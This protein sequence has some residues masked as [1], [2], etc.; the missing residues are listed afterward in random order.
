M[1]TAIDETASDHS[2]PFVRNNWNWTYQAPKET[3]AANKMRPAREFG[4]VFGSE[5]MKNANRRNAPFSRRW[6]GIAIGW[7]SHIEYPSTME[8]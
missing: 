4:V 2:R 1:G 6:S 3:S 5:I 8:R 7:P